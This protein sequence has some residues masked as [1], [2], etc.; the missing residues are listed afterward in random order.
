MAANLPPV[1]NVN[2]FGGGGVNAPASTLVPEGNTAGYKT[3][4][5]TTETGAANGSFFNFADPS[6]STQPYQVPAGKTFKMTQMCIQASCSVLGDCTV[7][8]GTATAAATNGNVAVPTGFFPW[9]TTNPASNNGTLFGDNSPVRLTCFN[10]PIDIAQNLYP[11]LK[12]NGAAY[13]TIYLIGKE[14]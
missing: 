1:L 2:Q 8:L 5:G 13:Q 4:I 3:L 9:A 7:L 6:T 12:V 14:I 10:T 11:V